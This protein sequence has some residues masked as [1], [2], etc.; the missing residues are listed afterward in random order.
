MARLNGRLIIYTGLVG[1]VILAGEIL[2]LSAFSNT[3][4]SPLGLIA[5]GALVGYATGFAITAAV[6]IT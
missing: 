2:M 3:S 6:A 5:G 1:L 4:I